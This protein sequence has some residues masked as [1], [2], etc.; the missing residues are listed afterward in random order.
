MVYIQTVQGSVVGKS[1]SFHSLAITGSYLRPEAPTTQGC[2]M[3]QATNGYTTIELCSNPL[4]Q[5]HIDSC[6]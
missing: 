6:T 4:F 2:Y 1:G 3:G 5:S